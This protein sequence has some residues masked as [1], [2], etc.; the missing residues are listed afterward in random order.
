MAETRKKGG[1]TVARSASIL[2]ITTFISSIL[3][4]IRNIVITSTFGAGIESDAYYA[5]FTVPDLIYTLLV[6][7]ALGAAFI[8]V[9]SSYIVV[10]DHD[11]ARKMG[12]S[13]YSLIGLM[14][15]AL[16]IL[17]II[18]ARPLM[19]LLVD[20]EGDA[21]SLTVL[22]TRIMFAQSF[23]MCLTGI[24]QG[25]LQSYKK[26]M[27]P[28]IGGV[29]YN[30]VIIFG[31]ILLSKYLRLG[32]MGFSMAVVLGAV[33]NFAIQIP[34]IRGQGFRYTPMLDI[35]HEGVKRFIKLVIP[36]LLGIGVSEINLIVNQKF[37]SGLEESTVTLLKQAQTIMVLPTRIFAAQLAVPM[38]PTL[39]GYVVKGMKKE[40]SHGVGKCFR[41]ILFIIVPVVVAFITI[42]EPMIRFLYKHGKFTEEN[43]H[44][45]ALLLAVYSIGILGWSL[46][47][48]ILRGFYSVNETKTPV[49]VN[50]T[51]LCLNML[52][53]WLLVK[54][55]GAAGLALAY[56]ISGLV[57]MSILAYLLR[58]KVGPY[59]GKKNLES[60]LKDF[61]SAGIMGGALIIL[62]HILEK[63]FGADGKTG[64]LLELIILAAVGVL[65]YL[66]MAYLLRVEELSDFL[67]M[68]KSRLHIG[69]RAK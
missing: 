55:L 12:S 25:V 57:S 46:R 14:S 35:H 42:R 4:Y 21:L 36:M 33:I 16:C 69:K 50:I 59:E 40:Y 26:F 54:P 61:V 39:S 8:P 31:G 67:K 47:E 34:F 30:V 58:R 65:V 10:D 63:V 24:S 44:T 1:E 6:G 2:V 56:S 64:Q 68:V 7:G 60:F 43:V 48:I 11:N 28:A 53:S 38:L 22:L 15:A 19:E 52:L 41:S 37:A 23:F 20:F 27:P 32:V 3:G 18:F 5:A 9:F 13:V 66:V 49:K 45:V 62:T 51:I 29:C 17:G